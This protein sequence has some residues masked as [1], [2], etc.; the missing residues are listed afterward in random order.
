MALLRPWLLMLAVLAGAL[1]LA[2]N[3]GDD[4]DDD[5]GDAG[6]QAAATQPA[7]GDGEGDG[8]GGDADGDAGGDV[9]GELRDLAARWGVTEVKVVYNMSTTL[10]GE[11]QDSTMTLYWKPPDSW[12]MDMAVAGLDSTL[13][14]AEGKAYVC[15]TGQCIETP[16][17]DAIPVPFLGDLTDPDEFAGLIDDSITGVD[18]DRSSETIAGVDATCFSF[19][20]TFEGEAGAGSYCF[21]DDG[22]LLRLEAGGTDTGV[23]S[24]EATSVED[25]VS[26]ED[27][28]PPFPVLEIPGLE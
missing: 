25:E 5:G 20:G 22:L 15:T 8:D 23:F 10:A 7:D 3:G 26:D 16:I 28:E 27:L 13:I 17:E 6:G 21:S 4:G 19:E 9:S 24:L 2:C 18:I 1:F 14:S 11:S 12:R